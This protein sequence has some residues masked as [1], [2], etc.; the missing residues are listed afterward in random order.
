MLK[1][2]ARTSRVSGNT[3]FYG[4][5]VH[6]VYDHPHDTS[7]L[8][9]DLLQNTC[10]EQKEPFCIQSTYIVKSAIKRIRKGN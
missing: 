6:L 7:R 5:C 2:K 9:W 10:S 8:L 4:S 3:T 1:I